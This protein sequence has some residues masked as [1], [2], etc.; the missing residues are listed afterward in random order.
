MVGFIT[1]IKL[2][3]A[4]TGIGGADNPSSFGQPSITLN[5]D[6]VFLNAKSDS[7]IIAAKKDI[8]NATSW[9]MEM[10]KLFTLIEKLASELKDLTSAS[11]TYATGVGTYDRDKC[12]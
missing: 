10:D 9:Q 11:A 4:Q 8:I 1:K 7:I 5:S 6:R 2:K 3:P 12:W